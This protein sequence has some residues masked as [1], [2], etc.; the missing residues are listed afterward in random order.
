VNN[1]FEKI[2]TLPTSPGVYIFKEAS[3]VIYVGK[4]KVI[5]KRVKQYFSNN[6]KDLKTNVLVKKIEDIDFI[7]TKTENEALILECDLIKR[8]KPKYNIL[9]KDDKSYPYI[10]I[11]KKEKYPGI[12]YFRGKADI[13]NSY[14]GPYTDMRSLRETLDKI[15]Q[16]FRLRTCSN[17]YFANRSRPCILYQINRCSAP[18][19]GY[20]SEE[21]YS[22][23]IDNVSMFLEQ[24]SDEIV[25]EL[26]KVMNKHVASLEYECAAKVRDQIHALKQMQKKQEVSAIAGNIDVF[27]FDF[28]NTNI[29]CYYLAVRGGK[30]FQ[31]N[32]FSWTSVVF[33]ED[34]EI[35]SSALMQFYQEVNSSNITHIVLNIKPSSKEYIEQ[36]LAKKIGYKIAIIHKPKQDKE[37]WLNIAKTNCN[38]NYDSNALLH[39]INNLSYDLELK[40]IPSNI[41]CFDISH[42]S[43]T[44][45]IASCVVFKNGI[46]EKKSYRAYKVKPLVAADDYEA[47]KIAI[48]KRYSAKGIVLE[49]LPDLIIIDGGKGQLS[50]VKLALENMQILSYVDL[51]SISKGEGRK[52]GLET[53][54]FTNKKAIS[55]ELDKISHRLLLSIR[56]EAHKYALR[57]HVQSRNKTSLKSVL[58]EIPGIGPKKRQQ[59]LHNFSNI[60]SIKEARI[61]DLTSI[62]GVDKKLANTIKDFFTDK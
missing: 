12:Y 27:Y 9:L 1:I 4:A 33:K 16:I 56:N 6:K 3:Q 47:L 15:Q 37:R 36:F 39:T 49:N 51:I 22:A 31:N 44:N 43:G 29:K 10:K 26:S 50:A 32:F 60:N 28:T 20:I 54:H 52:E 11:T 45:A 41:E 14:Y 2:K 46:A 19:M 59:L 18:C 21:D 5:K 48:T 8:F 38:Y 42:T 17:S 23:S 34:H 7:I 55:I 24:K 35:V 62:A 30:V 40:S 57:R 53:V 13:K 58:L 25:V 61:E